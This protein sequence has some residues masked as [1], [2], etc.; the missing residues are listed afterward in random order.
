MATQ[1]ISTRKPMG[2]LKKGLFLVAGLLIVLVLLIFAG[3]VY[4]TLAESAVADQ[5]PAPGQI[6][7]VN[8]RNMHTQCL[9]EGSPTIILDAGQHS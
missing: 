8:G 4:E 3:V 7:E 2:C 9:G 6:V 5:Y 1:S